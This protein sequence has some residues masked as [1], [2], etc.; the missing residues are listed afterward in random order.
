MMQTRCSFYQ[1]AGVGVILGLLAG[2][3]PS[4]ADYTIIARWRDNSTNEDGFKLWRKCDAETSWTLRQ[5]TAANA[6]SVTDTILSSLHTCQ[7]KVN[8]FI[9]STL[10][11]DSN[12]RT[13]YL[14]PNDLNMRKDTTPFGTRTG[15]RQIRK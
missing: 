8:S 12:T 9:G 15:A 5:T 7:Y 6:V 10:S 13:V 14:P 2:A 3:A 4:L 11:A 1:W